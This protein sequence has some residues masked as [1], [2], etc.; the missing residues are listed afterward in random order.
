M[1]TDRTK[2]LDLQYT[3]AEF[4]DTTCEK[5]DLLRQHHY[6]AK[7]Q[8]AFLKQQK[9]QINGNEIIVLLDFAENYS[10]LVQDAV[11][12][13]HWENSQATLHPFAVYFKNDV[14]EVKCL[15]ICIIS[16]SMKHDSN[17]VHAFI[18]S[19]LNYI[20]EKL[21]TVSKVVYFSDGAASQYKNFKN[22]VNLCHH[23]RDHDLNAQWH[24]FA[25]SHGKSPCDGLGGTTKRLVAKASLQATVTNQILTPQQMFAWADQNIAGIK[26]LYV[27][28]KDIAKNFQ[29]FDLEERYA[30]CKTI[31][32]TRSHHSFIPISET[33]LEMKR[34]SSDVFGNQF[35][36]GFKK[37]APCSSRIAQIQND[38]HFQPGHCIACKYDQHWYV[39]IITERCDEQK[40]VYVKFMHCNQNHT[41]SWPYN[42]RNECWVPF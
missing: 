26:Y 22:L 42:A 15:N 39:G 27:S 25:T 37:H 19:A 11:Q 29:D 10:F 7:S 4:I 31:P 32:G 6:I 41:L 12:G 24:F 14:G 33:A 17:A 2:L 34:L 30:R 35:S 16:D 1:H 9:Q 20:R 21:P 18:R 28:E 40:D 23:K 13:Y 38:A 5:F 3:V 36:F 8:S